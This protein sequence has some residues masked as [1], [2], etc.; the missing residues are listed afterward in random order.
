MAN[1]GLVA[2]VGI[3]GACTGM[4]VETLARLV[5]ACGRVVVLLDTVVPGFPRSVGRSVGAARFWRWFNVVLARYMR[6]VD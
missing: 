6:E 5:E 1:V 2:I 4:A 3:G